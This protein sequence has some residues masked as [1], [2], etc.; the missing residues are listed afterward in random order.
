MLGGNHEHILGS[1]CGNNCPM[2]YL[3]C[4]PGDTNVMVHIRWMIPFFKLYLQDAQ[5]YAAVIW[6]RPGDTDIIDGIGDQV[7]VENVIL[8]PRVS[9]TPSTS[10]MHVPAAGSPATLVDVLVAENEMRCWD[11]YGCPQERYELIVEY[12]ASASGVN[13]EECAS[14]LH[15]ETEAATVVVPA[16]ANATMTASIEAAAGLATP[17]KIGFRVKTGRNALSSIVEVDVTVDCELSAWTSWSDGCD[18]C[19]SSVV[20]SGRQSA[21]G[22]GGG[23]GGSNA[24]HASPV[25]MSRLEGSLQVLREIEQWA[26]SSASSRRGATKLPALTRWVEGGYIEGPLLVDAA[27]EVRASLNAGDNVSFADDCA[28]MKRAVD[29]NDDGTIGDREMQLSLRYASRWLAR[30]I[31]AAEALP[32]GGVSN[33]R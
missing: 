22:R 10:S 23:G 9:V 3:C 31:N 32:A 17:C 24:L 13:H 8:L 21:L 12:V 15:I 2:E 16:E 19:G 1:A 28:R 6:D 14:L 29:F 5:E 33:A 25:S 11:E 20:V 26:S 30:D 27:R 18:C 4:W 7:K